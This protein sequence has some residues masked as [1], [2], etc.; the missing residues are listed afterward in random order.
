M[1]GGVVLLLV[2]MISLGVALVPP[3][4]GVGLR[5][6]LGRTDREPRRLG[7]LT[8][9]ALGESLVAVPLSEELAKG[10]VLLLL[11]WSRE[12]DG[13]ASGL[14]YGAATGMGFA[15][16]ENLAYFV[17]AYVHDGRDTW[18][19]SLLTRTMFAAWMHTAASAIFGLLL[20][21][22][23]EVPL[24]RWKYLG[25]P[26]C[27]LLAAYLIHALWDTTLLLGDREASLH[28]YSVVPLVGVVLLVSVELALRL[29]TRTLRREL[30]EEAAAG[31]LPPGHVEILASHA[32][33]RGRAWLTG[34]DAG[35]DRDTYVRLGLRLAMCKHAARFLSPRAAAPYL[36]EAA[37]LRL[38]LR[39]LRRSEAVGA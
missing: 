8:S 25:A 18:I 33:R 39:A 19:F 24:G 28:L 7:W 5:V 38:R 35:L 26:L 3:T 27:G 9:G 6:L 22:A 14:C 21:R 16:A 32:R 20:G 10:L 29:E 31:V 12:L 11:F 4:V 13:A 17:T 23:R 1:M 37:A 2:V 36:E 30:Q 15:C 34:P